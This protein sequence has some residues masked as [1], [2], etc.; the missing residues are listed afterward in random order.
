MREKNMPL[1]ALEGG[2]WIRRVLCFVFGSSALNCS[3]YLWITRPRRD[4]W[5]SGAPVATG[6]S[7]I[8]GCRRW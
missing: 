1:Y 4:F 2:F 3:D 5:R 8:Y 6:S 7:A